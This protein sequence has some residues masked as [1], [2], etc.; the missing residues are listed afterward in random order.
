MERLKVFFNPKWKDRKERQEKLFADAAAGSAYGYENSVQGGKN[1][2]N[3]NKTYT[4][5]YVNGASIN[6]NKDNDDGDKFN[7]KRYHGTNYVGGYDKHKQDGQTYTPQEYK[8]ADFSEYDVDTN[9]QDDLAYDTNRLNIAYNRGRNA[10]MGKYK[11]GAKTFGGTPLTGT[12]RK[13][14]MYQELGKQN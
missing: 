8:K 4:P 14:G 11:K 7:I 12:G 2:H 5:G 10:S 6:V 1:Y 9:D 3:F 13:N